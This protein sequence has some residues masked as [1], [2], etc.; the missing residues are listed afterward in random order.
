MHGATAED[1][2]GTV[3]RW[4]RAAMAEAAAVGRTGAMAVWEV[5]GMWSRAVG[6]EE[7]LQQLTRNGCAHRPRWTAVVAGI[8]GGRLQNASGGGDARWGA[9]VAADPRLTSGGLSKTG[10]Q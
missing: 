3:A 10:A 5:A 7:A 8:S 6:L 1:E 9:G 4:L 2:E